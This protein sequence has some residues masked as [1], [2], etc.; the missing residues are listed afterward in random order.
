MAGIDTRDHTDRFKDLEGLRQVFCTPKM[1]RNGRASAAKTAIS[2][3]PVPH[4]NDQKDVRKAAPILPT[5]V[6]QGKHIAHKSV[7]PS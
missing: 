4:D 7:G 2:P 3:E 6:P 1:V 5:N